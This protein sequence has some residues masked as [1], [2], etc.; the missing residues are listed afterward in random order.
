MDFSK[1]MDLYLDL[2]LL[3]DY[4]GC[5]THKMQHGQELTQPLTMQTIS[6]RLFLL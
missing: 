4:D 6:M 2:V 3:S 1:M 5:G